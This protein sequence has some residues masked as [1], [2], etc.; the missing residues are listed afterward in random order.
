MTPRTWATDRVVITEEIIMQKV[1]Q[2]PEAGCWIW[3]GLSY[4]GGYGMVYGGNKN[5]RAHRITYEMFKGPIPAG[6][7]IDHLCRVPAC[8]NPHHLEAVTNQVNSLRG[9]GPT[10]INKKK[11][12]CPRGHAFIPE[13]T[14]IS[15]AGTRCCRICANAHTRRYR[16]A[17]SDA[18]KLG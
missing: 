12:H 3:E 16:K 10:A 13:N 11:S 7:Q 4:P 15:R 9:I 5:Y 8:V 14:K 17:K 18:K 1:V 6:L 2:I